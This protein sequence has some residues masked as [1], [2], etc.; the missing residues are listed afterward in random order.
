MN[1]ECRLDLERVRRLVGDKRDGLLDTLPKL[2]LIAERDI[3]EAAASLLKLPL[4]AARDYPAAPLLED[5]L[6]SRFHH[7]SRVLPQAD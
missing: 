3:A 2:G 7:E 6:S 1:L 4:V 5:K